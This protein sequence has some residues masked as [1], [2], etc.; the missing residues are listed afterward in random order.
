MN[1]PPSWAFLMAMTMRRC[2][3]ERI[4]QCSMSMVTLE[5]TGRRHRANICPVL[6]GRTPW[7]LILGWKIDLWCC[8]IAFRS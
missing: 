5:G 8:D 6:P 1:V 4:T 7:S 3:A 2:D